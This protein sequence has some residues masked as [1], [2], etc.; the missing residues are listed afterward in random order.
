VSDGLWLR[1]V[2]LRAAL[3]LRHYEAGDELVLEVRDSFCPWNDGRWRLETSE[4]GATCERTDSEPD[5]TLATSAL[6]A[7]YLGGVTVMRLFAAG[8]IEGSLDAVTRLDRLLRVPRAPWPST[9]F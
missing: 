7:A 8:L 6:G 4:K 1:L 9:D 2:D 3:A 5:L